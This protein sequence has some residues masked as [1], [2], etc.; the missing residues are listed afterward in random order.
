MYKTI[1]TTKAKKDFVDN[2]FK[3][4]LCSVYEQGE[5]NDE[6]KKLVMDYVLNI[7]ENSKLYKRLVSDDMYYIFLQRNHQFIKVIQM[8]REVLKTKGEI[9]KS[10]LPSDKDIYGI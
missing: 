4:C 10:K 1:A 7:D 5:V 3:W 2:Y 8:A 6:F 9:Q